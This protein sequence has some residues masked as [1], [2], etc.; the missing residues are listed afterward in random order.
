MDEDKWCLLNVLRKK[1]LVSLLDQA[2]G[3]GGPGEV[4]KDVG[5]QEVV[6]GGMCSATCGQMLYLLP[7]GRLV[8]ADEAYHC[9]VICKLDYGGGSLY[10]PAVVKTS[11]GMGSEHN[12]AVRR[13]NDNDGGAGVA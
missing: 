7:V 10:R 3:V 11:T 12:P 2:G 1:V 9:C 8:V 6:A 4:I 5:P 13:C